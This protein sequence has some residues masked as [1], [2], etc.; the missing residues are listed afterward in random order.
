MTLFVLFVPALLLGLPVFVAGWVMYDRAGRL[1]RTGVPAH[2]QVVDVRYR[3]T[4]EGHRIT[5]IVLWHTA[6]GQPRHQA[7]QFPTSALRTL[8]PG[9]P[10]TLRYDPRNPSRVRVD[11]TPSPRGQAV[12]LM[13]FGGIVLAVAFMLL[14]GGLAT[15]L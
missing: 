10:V 4:D 5:H 11:G 6:Q 14:L 2:G 15:A 9:A 7:V 1:E 12:V 3:R 8:Y 13:V